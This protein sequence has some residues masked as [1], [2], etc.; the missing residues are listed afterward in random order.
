MTCATAVS[1][2]KRQLSQTGPPQAGLFPHRFRSGTD[3]GPKQRIARAYKRNGNAG[4][5]GIAKPAAI[6]RN[7]SPAWRTLGMR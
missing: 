2:H 6:S 3:A 5:K 4:R 7:F 1:K